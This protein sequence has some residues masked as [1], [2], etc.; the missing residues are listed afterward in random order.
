MFASAPNPRLDIERI[1][2]VRTASRVPLVLHG[3]SGIRDED[4]LSAVDAGVSV[5]HISTEL[6]RAWREGMEE[7]LHKD[8]KEIAPYKIAQPALAKLEDVIIS[9]LRLFSRL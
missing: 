3:G 4:F 9:R 2:E 8:E 5:I 6:R 1:R 7:G